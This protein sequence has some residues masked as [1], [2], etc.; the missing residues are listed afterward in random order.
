MSKRSKISGV[1]AH[2]EERFGREVWQPDHDVL[3]NLILTMLSQNTSDLNRDRAYGR[4]R[5]RFKSWREVARAEVSVLEEALRPG[6]LAQQKSR[7][8]QDVLVWVEETEGRMSLDFVCDM[9]VSEAIDLLTKLPGVGVKTVAVVL[10]F[11][12]GRDVFP[13]DTHVHRI[14]R[15]LGFVPRNATAE[16][17]FYLMEEIVPSGEKY[18]FHINLLKHGR[19]IC[20]AQNPRCWDCPVY[21]ACEYEGK[22]AQREK[23]G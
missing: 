21:R 16:K 9:S 4:M 3:D 2:L 19:T 8:I 23:G 14:C 17:T 1:I 10:A 20:K 12:C 13:V 22:E 11:A 18:S 7:R 5:E 6:G 15:R